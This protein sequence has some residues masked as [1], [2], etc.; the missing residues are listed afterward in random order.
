MRTFIVIIVSFFWPVLFVAAGLKIGL[1]ECT[2]QAM[3]NVIMYSLVGIFFG[4]IWHDNVRKRSI[5]VLVAALI[6]SGV[7]LFS[8][9]FAMG[10]DHYGACEIF[11]QLC[12]ILLPSIGLLVGDRLYSRQNVG[13]S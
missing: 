5:Y 11:N 2:Y 9:W 12:Y 6:I 3:T 4:Y 8:G 7:G 1:W 13:D 10:L